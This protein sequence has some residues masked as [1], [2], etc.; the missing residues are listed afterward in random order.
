M[1]RIDLKDVYEV[2][3]IEL[4]NCEEGKDESLSGKRWLNVGLPRRE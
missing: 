3:S 4:R 1:V 2:E